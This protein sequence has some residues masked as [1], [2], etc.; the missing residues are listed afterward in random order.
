M[1]LSTLH[2]VMARNLKWVMV[3]KTHVSPF[4]LMF[5]YPSS[6]KAYVNQSPTLLLANVYLYQH[7]CKQNG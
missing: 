5:L 3:M 1:G 6:L 2:E 7:S 4:S